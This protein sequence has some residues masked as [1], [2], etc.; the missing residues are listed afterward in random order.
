M[1][2]KLKK[3]KEEK[4]KMDEKNIIYTSQKKTSRIRLNGE[5]EWKKNEQRNKWENKMRKKEK[6]QEKGSILENFLKKIQTILCQWIL[7]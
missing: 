3:Q 7:N 1:Q 6:R 4:K 2:E 5:I